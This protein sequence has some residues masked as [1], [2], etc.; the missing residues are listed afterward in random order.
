MSVFEKHRFKI[1]SR[2]QHPYR[3]SLSEFSY[4][5]EALP[6]IGNAEDA[7]NYILAVLYPNVEPAV[8]TPG[9]LPATGNTLND[10]RV[11]R[12][13]GDGK[14]AAYRWE[15]REGEAAPSWH[16]V[17][18]MDW[19]NDSILAELV[20][21]TLPLYVS[22]LGTSD[23]DPAGDPVTGLYAGQLVYGGDQ[24]NQNLTLNANSGD[25]TGPQ[26]GFVQIDSQFRPTLTDTY[27]LS[28]ASERW[29]DAHF[30]GIIYIGAGQI[31]STVG[32]TPVTTTVGE[33][34]TNNDL[35]GIFDSNNDTYGQSFDPTDSGPLTKGFFE[36]GFLAS[37][38]GDITL[39]LRA[40]AAGSPGAVLATSDPINSNTFT[41]SLIEWTFSTPATVNAGTT[42]W[43]TIDRSGLTSGI[44]SI[45]YQNSDVYAGG[46]AAQSSDNGASWTINPTFDSVFR[47][48]IET[49]TGGQML[50][51]DQSGLIN[52]DNENLV[53]TGNINGNIVT[54]TQLVAD[55]T[56]NSMTLVPGS[57]TDTSGQISFG[58]ANLLTTGTLGAGV[59]T[60]TDSSQTLILQPFVS[61]PPDRAQITSS[62]GLISFDDEDLVTTGGLDVGSIVTDILDVDNLR[63]D[64]NTI[65]STDTDG[66]I[67]LVPDGV[68]VVDIQKALQALS[69][70]FT[71]FVTVNGSLDVD[72]VQID[73]QSVRSTLAGGNLFLEANGAGSI[74]FSHNFLPSSDGTLNIGVGVSRVN[75]I[76]MSGG[77]SDG[78]NTTSIATLLAF[79]SALFRDAAQTQPAQTGDALFFDDTLGLW[80]ASVPDSEVTHNTVSGLT[81]GDA[82]HT[83]FVMLEGRSGG[84]TI[85]GDTA[86][87]GNLV[88]GSTFDGTKGL[89]QTQDNF[90]PTADAVFG[91][92]WSGTDLGGSSLRWN[93]IY[94]AGEH[95]GLRFENILSTSLPAF[96][97]QTPGRVYFATDNQKAYVNTGTQV[98]PLGV[99][100]FLQDVSFNGTETTKDI[101]I[102]GIEDARNAIWQLMDNANQFEIM[103]GTIKV[104]SASNVRIETNSPLPAGSYRLIGIE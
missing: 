43:L 51:T 36:I 80:L 60:F 13:D 44:F 95:I 21:V 75:D 99:S 2:W 103:Q 56:T 67:N 100:K 68:G 92:P 101:A 24:A 62:L 20:D 77:L 28:T 69:A 8:D 5:N 94:S 71:G 32:T 66:N 14:Q 41:L 16:K 47:V 45:R 18:D 79:R 89:V 26:T 9:D 15:Q 1:F 81:N 12:D 59:A 49:L 23:L 88:L 42:Y 30:G 91:G 52:F 90:T 27:N 70:T 34:L 72:N 76:F 17:L 35:R 31:T 61:G 57:I 86:P 96:D 104:T 64:G 84:Q 74:V 48:Q 83:Q 87:S 82:G 38:V 54:G 25:G 10:Y 33:N 37:P 19:S 85:Y 102:T 97:G 29:L 58:A 55:D 6:G 78:T 53:T 98:K 40:D 46:T 3:H 93:N 63:L 50:I 4:Q 73:G 22:K 39:Q 65:S 11:V 7:F